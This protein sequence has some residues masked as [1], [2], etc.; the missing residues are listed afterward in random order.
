[1]KTVCSLLLYDNSMGQS[2]LYELKKS[3][4]WA[5]PSTNKL[6]WANEKIGKFLTMPRGK[7]AD[8]Q[9]IIVAIMFLKNHHFMF[10]RIIKPWTFTNTQIYKLRKILFFGD[11]NKWLNICWNPGTVLGT[12]SNPYQLILCSEHPQPGFSVP[13]MQLSLLVHVHWSGGQLWQREPSLDAEQ[14][15]C[16]DHTRKHMGSGEK[17]TN[18]SKRVS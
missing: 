12:D 7:K 1:M 3:T 10:L 16:I 17:I 13:Q 5:L 2:L 8:I 9:Q 14:S 11:I 18:G 6:F 15:G 4:T